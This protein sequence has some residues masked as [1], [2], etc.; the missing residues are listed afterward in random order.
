MS[1]YPMSLKMAA[2]HN[3]VN[4]ILTLPLKRNDYNHKLS[5][6]KHIAKANYYNSGQHHT[7]TI[8][9]QKHSAGPRPKQK[10]VCAKYKQ[11]LHYTLNK[12]LHKQI[13][14]LAHRTSNK[15]A[16]WGVI[17]KTRGNDF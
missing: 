15:L 17:R 7:Q 1:Y 9:K 10:Y 5:T 16:S 13:I 11:T 8:N 14:I 6:I 4:R 3:L 2:Y 12:E